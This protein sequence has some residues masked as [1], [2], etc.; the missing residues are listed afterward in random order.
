MLRFTCVHAQDCV[1][2]I[3]GSV[4]NGRGAEVGVYS[5]YFTVKAKCRPPIALK[6]RMISAIRYLRYD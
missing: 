1:L 2:V 4:A 6:A 3:A 5:N